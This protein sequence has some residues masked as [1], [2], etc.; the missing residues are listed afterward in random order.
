MKASK[1]YK[2]KSYGKKTYTFGMQVPRTG[3]ARGAMKLD[4][5]NKN[6]L[7]FDAQK[8]DAS[9]LRDMSTFELMPEKFDLTSYQCVPFIYTWDV[10]FDGRR[11]ACLVANRKVTIGSLEEDVWSGV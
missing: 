9:A 7:W 5:E 1:K 3:D 11:R 4:Q 10:K 6:N 8:K 2:K